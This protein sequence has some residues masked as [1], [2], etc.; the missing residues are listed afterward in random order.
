MDL[1]VGCKCGAVYWRLGVEGEV[2]QG[3]AA[4][5]VAACWEE[6]WV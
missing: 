3:L 4:K 1:L 6:R 5:V 2:V